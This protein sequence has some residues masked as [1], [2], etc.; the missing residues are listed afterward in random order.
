MRRILIGVCHATTLSS[1]YESLAGPLLKAGFNPVMTVDYGTIIRQSRSFGIGWIVRV[2][3]IDE[4]NRLITVSADEGEAGDRLIQAMTEAGIVLWP[5]SR[6][7]LVY[8]DPCSREDWFELLNQVAVRL[9]ETA[10]R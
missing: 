10:C 1:I 8:S 3:H 5:V 2:D 9:Q 4:E 6:P 7:I